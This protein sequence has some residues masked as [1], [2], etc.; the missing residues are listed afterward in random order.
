MVVISTYHQIDKKT[1]NRSKYFNRTWLMVVLDEAHK[2]RN[3]DTEFNKNCNALKA[4]YRLCLTG[5]LECVPV[6]AV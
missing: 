3:V 2:I 4:Q 5:M 6:V 1:K